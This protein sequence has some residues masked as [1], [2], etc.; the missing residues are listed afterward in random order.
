MSRW[1]DWQ[2][3]RNDPDT[4]PDQY[5]QA[6]GRK[7]LGELMEGVKR[8]GLYQNKIRRV[9]ADGTVVVA[10]FDGTTP[11]VQVIA[12]A[13]TQTPEVPTMVTLWI[14]RGFVFV[15]GS[16]ESPRGWGLPVI[17]QHDDTGWPFGKQ[18]L[19]P[20]LDVGRWTADGPAAQVL[21]TQDDTTQYPDGRKQQLPIGYDAKEWPASMDWQPKPVAWHVARP[22]FDGFD[23]TPD[24][25]GARIALWRAVTTEVD[26]SMMA[27]PFAGYYDDA[28]IFAS[29]S[30]KYG[31]DDTHWPLDYAPIAVRADK[32]GYRGAYAES[33][34]A[35]GTPAQLAAGLTLSDTAVQIDVGVAG[36]ITTATERP[37]KDWI[38]CGNIF[39]HPDDPTLPT[40]TWDGYPAQNLPFWLVEGAWTGDVGSAIFPLEGWNYQWRGQTRYVYSKNLYAMGRCIGVLPDTVI[41]AAIRIETVPIEDQPGKTKRVHRVVVIT[42]RPSDQFGDASGIAYW[43]KFRV[44]CVDFDIKAGMPL[45]VSD[46]P[47]GAY[48]ATTNPMGWRAAGTFSVTPA[49]SATA[50]IPT[51]LPDHTVWQAWRF[52]GTGSHAV[53][54]YGVPPYATDVQ[55]PSNVCEVAFSTIEQGS[56]DIGVQTINLGSGGVLAADYDAAGNFAWVWNDTHSY[57]AVTPLGIEDAVERTLRWSGGGDGEIAGWAGL[58][59]LL[60]PEKWVLDARDGAMALVDHWFVCPADDLAAEGHYQVRLARKGARVATDGYVDG[61]PVAEADWSSDNFLDRLNASF[62]R[63]RAGNVVMGYDLGTTQGAT[64]VYV[65]QPVCGHAY[66]ATTGAPVS[67][68]FGS[69]WLFGDSPMQFAGLPDAPMRAF[70]IGVC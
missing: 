41:A 69:N 45:H 43:W 35:N 59:T 23:W 39:W 25:R 3:T 22:T 4:P 38:R 53:A 20:G 46:V 15:P 12:P 32:D 48:D 9:F 18:N 54:A 10:Q 37:A 1:E 36:G 24:V 14:P 51:S 8:G 52:N 17:Q 66:P 67:S 29:L 13:T 57:D 58:T 31:S 62:A 70:P 16:A 47:V 21:L 2:R 11:M 65:T 7:V 34:Y 30:N 40:L 56:L 42:W 28:Q 27:L 44:W 26:K 50:G 55:G 61:L 6:L 68:Y 60:V 5:Q 63:D 64:P 19:A 33:R 49:T